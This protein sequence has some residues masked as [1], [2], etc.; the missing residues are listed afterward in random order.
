MG[1]TA[2]FVLGITDVDIVGVTD[3]DMVGVNVRDEVI[4]TSV[5]VTARGGFTGGVAGGQGTPLPL[6][7][8]AGEGWWQKTNGL[9]KLVTLPV[10]P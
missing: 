3:V 5:G 10:L 1:V 7:E 8:G 2:G 9:R 6:V 4:V